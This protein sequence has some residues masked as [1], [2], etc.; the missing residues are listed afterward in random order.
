MAPGYSFNNHYMHM[1]LSSLLFLGNVFFQ[2]MTVIGLPYL[3][4][5]NRGHFGRG[6]GGGIITLVNF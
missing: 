1:S 2:V 3:P 5:Q 4:I 6:G